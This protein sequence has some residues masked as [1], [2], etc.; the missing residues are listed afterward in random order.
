MEGLNK[1]KRVNKSLAINKWGGSTYLALKKKQKQELM[2]HWYVNDYKT[3]QQIH[4]TT[5]HPCQFYIVLHSHHNFHLVH[6][7]LQYE[8]FLFQ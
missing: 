7:Q 6:V 5:C 8:C 3:M 4:N 2:N 1:A